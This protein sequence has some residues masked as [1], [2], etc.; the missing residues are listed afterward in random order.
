MTCNFALR[1]INITVQAH[2][3]IQQTLLMH[4]GCCKRL[5]VAIVA[6]LLVGPLV[7]V[8]G[9]DLSRFQCT[10]NDVRIIG[11]GQIIN[12]PC[13][14]P[15]GS[16]FNAQ[17]QFT[18]ENNAAS[19][20]SCM[21]LHLCPATVNG[22]QIN[23]GDIILNGG[24]P[25]PGKT[26]RTVTATIPNYPCG[27]NLVCFGVAGQDDRGR[28]DVGT[29]CST[30]SWGVPGQDACPPD[31]QISSKCRHQQI[32]IQGRPTPTLACDNCPI[33][34]DASTATLRLCSGSGSPGQ[35]YVLV[36]PFGPIPTPPLVGN[37]AVYH[38]LPAG[39]YTGS[40][41]YADGCTRSV[42]YTVETTPG[43]V[44]PPTVTASVDCQNR[45]TL[46][47]DSTTTRWQTLTGEPFTGCLEGTNTGTACTIQTSYSDQC[48][49]FACAVAVDATG[50]R[51]APACPYFEECATIRPC[52]PPTQAP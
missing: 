22:Q 19:D 26:T 34:P 44:P 52:F 21:T 47:A 17:V 33:C 10:A 14:C 12:E 28:C 38:N 13:S 30:V 35:N 2:I 45:V 6:F 11:V 39:L 41:T 7:L 15:T 9:D 46:S 49:Q 32:C 8:Y 24:D 3:R 40:V 16:V 50:C 43:N 18:V 20:R 23:L 1:S 36:G 31:R 37:C 51:S 4:L 48:R 27:T 42:V 29:C 5:L 25:I